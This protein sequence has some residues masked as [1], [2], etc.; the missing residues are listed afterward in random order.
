VKAAA[1]VEVA[2]RDRSDIL[3]DIRSEPPLTLRSTGDRVLLVGSAAGPV[4]GDDLALD[5]VVGPGARLDLGTV[6][7]TLA[8]PGPH[9]RESTQTI[10]ATVAEG[11]HLQ[12][13]PEPLVAVSGCRHRAVTRIEL[14]RAATACVTEEIVLGR[15]G[16]PPGDLVLDWRL[17]RD[18]RPLVHHAE[19]LGPRAPGWGSMV[20][21]GAHRHLL[22][23]VVVGRGCPD[24][25]PIVGPDAA[26]AV[27]RLAPDAWLLLATGATRTSVACAAAA[28]LV[29]AGE[30]ARRPRPRPM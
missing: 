22:A 7:A 13:A 30:E 1:R 23:T 11:G 25:P 20:T 2:R 14:A 21:V 8:W 28:Q 5:V 3:V 24:R 26:A 10:A 17:E 16:E 29:D 19:R 6:A 4:G 15:R 12:W 18:G 27:L 9:G